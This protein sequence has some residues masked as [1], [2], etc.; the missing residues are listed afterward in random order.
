MAETDVQEIQQTA[1]CAAKSTPVGRAVMGR[2]ECSAA[3]TAV[4]DALYVIGGK[5]KLRIIIA[6]TEGFTRFNELQRRVD[7]ISARVLSNELKDLELNG[8]LVRTV[9]AGSPVAVEYI[10]T[11]Y[12]DTLKDVLQSLRE[13]GTMHRTNIK[14]RMRAASQAT[15]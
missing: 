8:F 10:L 5:W 7:G 14:N 3:L 4:G 12:A 13:W 2:S 9:Q 15:S 1:E 11:D 6:L